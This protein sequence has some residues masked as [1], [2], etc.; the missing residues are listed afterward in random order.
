MLFP[1]SSRFPPLSAPPWEAGTSTPDDLAS[2]GPSDMHTSS[3]IWLQE[4]FPKD[5]H[6]QEMN[7]ILDFNSEGMEIF[8]ERWVGLPDHLSYSLQQRHKALPAVSAGLSPLP[9]VVEQGD[10]EDTDVSG[11]PQVSP[12]QSPSTARRVQQ[13]VE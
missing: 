8:L 4:H 2:D 13:A 1:C 5:L 10:F 12:P 3:K 9:V 7:F 11:I 6:R